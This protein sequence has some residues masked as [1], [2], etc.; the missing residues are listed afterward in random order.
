M[1]E[2]VT[3]LD[4]QFDSRR[5]DFHL[6]VNESLPASGVTGVFGASG[7]GKTTL[8][9]CIA[10]LETT[11]DLTPVHKRRVGYVFQE[12]QLFAH[13]DVCGNIEYGIKRNDASVD[14]TAIVEM[15][16]IGNLLDRNVRHL[17]GGEAQRVSIARVLC[18]SPQLVLMDEPLSALDEARKDEVLPFLDRLR[19][20]SEVP[21]VYVSHN[22]GEICRLADHLLVM[23]EGRV[24]ASGP[25]QETLTRLDLPQ[26][27]GANAGTVIDARRCGYDDAHDLT[28]FEFSGGE[29]WAARR[30]EAETVRLRIQASDVSLTLEQPASTTILNVLP[31]TID[32]IEADSASTCL[33]RLRAGSDSILSRITRRS[34]SELALQVGMSVYAQIKSVIVRR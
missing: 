2:T 31:A 23:D 20:E 21:I 17:S 3:T 13:L 25:L 26:L 10:G 11:T 9:R 15:L 4:L 12:P 6:Q 33:V 18:Q 34:Q 1:A 14:V 8:L 19:A 28:R 7:C 22:I 16:G 32:A 29:L 27:G 30:Y 24:V 5:G